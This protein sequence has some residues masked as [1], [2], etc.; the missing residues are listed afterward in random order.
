M[1]K[2]TY[3]QQGTAIDYTPAAAVD[4]GDVIVQ[5]ELIGIAKLDIAA[6]ALGALATEGV[7]DLAKTTSAVFATG[8][9]VYWDATNE[10]ATP[11][12]S[13][14]T[15]FGPAVAASAAAATTVRAKLVQDLGGDEE[16]PAAM[17]GLTFEDVEDDKTLD[18]QDVGKVMNVTVDAKTITL[19][20][21]AA[22][23]R[24]VI[25]CGAA[26]GT[27]GVAVSP[28]AND[29]IMGAD[30]AGVDNK[31]RLLLKATAVLGDYIVLTYGG[32]TGWLVEAESGTWSA[33]A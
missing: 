22:G 29:K 30:L 26:D 1:A 21:V 10:E 9:A 7:F 14:N 3:V 2:A 13:G 6:S 24:F 27:V 15:F 19:P 5:R 32:A 16:L 4:A 25:R 20:A 18:I 31:D 11:E 8:Q 12:P 23:L 33:E 17:Q 28:N